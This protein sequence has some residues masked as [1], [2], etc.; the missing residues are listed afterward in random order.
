MSDPYFALPLSNQ[1]RHVDVALAPVAV[2]VDAFLT[3]LGFVPEIGGQFI[4][5]ERE[6]GASHSANDHRPMTGKGVPEFHHAIWPDIGEIYNH[7]A[8]TVYGFEYFHVNEWNSR[9]IPTNL[10][11]P[12][13]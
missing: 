13:H 11:G 9:Y 5:V 10:G 8:R 6:P 2:L 1:R 12:H 7:E 3:T 4:L